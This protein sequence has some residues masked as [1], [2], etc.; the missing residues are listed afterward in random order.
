MIGLGSDKN[1]GKEKRK[2]ECKEEGEKYVKSL[3]PASEIFFIKYHSF[4]AHMVDLESKH[5]M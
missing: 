4:G 2:P 1:Q 5:T 3:D